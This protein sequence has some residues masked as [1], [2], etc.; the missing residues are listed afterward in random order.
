VLPQRPLPRKKV[1]IQINLCIN[2][3]TNNLNIE[4]CRRDLATAEKAIQ[5]LRDQLKMQD[6]L[7]ATKDETISLLRA[8]YNRPN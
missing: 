8:S 3:T 6:G 5:H 7:I 2:S 4:N 1:S